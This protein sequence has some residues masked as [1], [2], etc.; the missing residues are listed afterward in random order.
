MKRY[1]F[2]TLIALCGL[3]SLWGQKEIPLFNPSFEDFPR[4][5]TPPKYWDDC[6]FPGETPVDVQPGSWGVKLKAAKGNTY[7]GMVTREYDTFESASQELISPLKGGQCYE[8]VA[9]LAQSKTYL[10]RVVKHELAPLKDF[11]EPVKLRIF[12]GNSTCHRGQLL[13]ESPLIDHEKWIPYVF[14]LQPKKDYT[15]LILEVFYK[16]PVLFPYNGNLLVDNLSN[17]VPIDCEKEVIQTSTSHLQKPTVAIVQPTKVIDR[18]QKKY[19][20]TAKTTFVNSKN[21]IQIKLNNKVVRDFKFDVKSGI[22]TVPLILGKSKNDIEILVINKDGLAK[23]DTSITTTFQIEKD[24]PKLEKDEKT[25]E[26]SVQ[27]KPKPTEKVYFDE[28]KIAKLKVGDIL[29]LERLQFRANKADVQSRYHDL[30]N[31]VKDILDE[32]PTI[33]LEIGGHTNSLPKSV[34]YRVKL[35]EARAKAV[36]N[37]LINKGIDRNRLTYKGYGSSKPIASDKSRAG[38]IK[39]QRVELR[40]IAT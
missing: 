12:A 32:N 35:S 30:L 10:S 38:R 8:F 29:K 11:I 21:D 37:Y 15:H 24:L 40:V 28:K 36:Y 16:T 9:Y 34:D 19:L 18:S 39:N 1:I 27:N 13:A 20:V 23:D 5:S 4:V 6:S 22:I 3:S 25:D 14:K 17:L 2:S 7:L 26:I 33:K 31:E